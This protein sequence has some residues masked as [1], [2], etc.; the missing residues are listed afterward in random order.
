MITLGKGPKTNFSR[1]QIFYQWNQQQRLSVG[2]I[3]PS[4]ML[5]GFS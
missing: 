2:K 3:E 4:H 5:L 1:L